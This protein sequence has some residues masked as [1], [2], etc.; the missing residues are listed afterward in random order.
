[1]DDVM[2]SLEKAGFCLVV[3]ALLLPMFFMDIFTVT[4]AIWTLGSVLFVSGGEIERLLKK[5][6]PNIP[7]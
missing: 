7:W 4:V 3:M 1:M 6:W 2:N 5:R